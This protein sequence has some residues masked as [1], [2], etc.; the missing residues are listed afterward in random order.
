MRRVIKVRECL[1]KQFLCYNFYHSTFFFS[2]TIDTK[3]FRT[4]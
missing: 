2:N 1:E 3:N 4:T